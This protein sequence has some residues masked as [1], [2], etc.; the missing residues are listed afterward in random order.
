M[1]KVSRP[2]A[3]FEDAYQ[4]PLG[5]DSRPFYSMK[6]S[7]F[8]VNR[9]DASAFTNGA[10]HACVSAVEKTGRE[11]AAGCR[12]Y[13]SEDQNRL[14]VKRYVSAALE[15]IFMLSEY[16]EH[17][18]VVAS[19]MGGL[20][21]LN[22][23]MK[24]AVKFP[25]CKNKISFV[26]LAPT[27]EIYK[28]LNSADGF[29][30]LDDGLATATTQA[31][32][33]SYIDDNPEKIN[34]VVA[35]IQATKRQTNSCT[36]PR[37]APFYRELI[38]RFQDNSVVVL[39]L[40]TKNNLFMQLLSQQSDSRVDVWSHAQQN[41]LCPEV[42]VSIPEDVATVGAMI[43]EVPCRD[44]GVTLSTLHQHAIPLDPSVEKRL[45]D[46]QLDK[47]EF[48]IFADQTRLIALDK[49][50]EYKTLYTFAQKLHEEL[51]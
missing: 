17:V 4:P 24:E 2:A 37:F 42:I 5:I 39:P 45:S 25:E 50:L 48:R 23:V 31:R 1:E 26:P 16:T 35:G 21:P 30:L 15:S 13:F 22:A 27:V 11:V 38:R 8:L 29:V 46:E 7:D 51:L 14:H 3:D 43:D 12:V 28:H 34:A 20:A 49:S 6:R 18:A 47:A 33:L 44:M 32:L 41:V 36:D 40:F 10:L 9:R 19:P